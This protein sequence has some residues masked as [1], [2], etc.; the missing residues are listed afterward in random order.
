M[1][2]RKKLL[3]KNK[4]PKV[5]KFQPLAAWKKV[6]CG[7]LVL[8]VV[9]L[10][11]YCF[12]PYTR[13]TALVCTGN[14]Y[15]TP[16][17]IYRIADLSVNN[18]TFTVP[19][20]DVEQK[21]TEDPLIESADVYKDGQNINID[22]NEKMIIG[23]YEENGANYLVSS[24]G[25]RI[26]VENETELRSL[27]HFPLMADLP[28][29]TIDAIA[30]QVSTHS[31]KLTREVFEKIAE[32]L[33]WQESYDKNMLKL[34]LQDGNTVFTSIP[35]LFM[36]S[37]Y[38]QVLN[39]LQGENVC[40]LFDGANGVINKVAC[41]YM[42]LSQEERAE[43]REIP[44]SVL[45]PELYPHE[46]S[47]EQEE[48]AQ[49]SVETPAAGPANPQVPADLGSIGDWE[50]SA[51]DGIQYSPSTG[52]FYSNADGIYYTYDSASD[53]FYPY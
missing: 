42:Y 37:A 32:I 16:Q 40:F 5:K 24:T 4:Q 9:S 1:A 23:Y 43:N 33:P 44:K 48:T 21:L 34:V 36:I 2:N 19:E 53:T 13:V 26:K 31:D 27:I 25:E 47:K 10:G 20:S 28:S 35:S 22:V 49:P 15:Y 41:S 30:K 11:V 7:L 45:N 52:L 29:E 17:Q 38:Q 46:D 8:A 39:N 3:K 14:Y 50:A 6:G 18:R 12:S 51:V